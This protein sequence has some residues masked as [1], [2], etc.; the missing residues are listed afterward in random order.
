M[1]FNDGGLSC[2]LSGQHINDYIEQLV[3]GGAS[4]KG[5]RTWHATVFAACRLALAAADLTSRGEGVARGRSLPD[6]E[7]RKK[8]FSSA[9]ARKLVREVVEETAELLGNT[10]AVARGSYIDPRVIDEFHH[11]AVVDLRQKSMPKGPPFPPRIEA[12]V[13]DFLT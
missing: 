3:G 9:G 12:A 10:P 5:F 13:L 11:G 2:D 4:A 1:H 6:A 8:M 7:H